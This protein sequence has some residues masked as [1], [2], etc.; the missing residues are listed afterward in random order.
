MSR[1]ESVSAAYPWLLLH[2]DVILAHCSCQERPSS[3]HS[4]GMDDG[5]AES[6][7]YG[8]FVSCNTGIEILPSQLNV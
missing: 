3:L 5:A 2:P 6:A 4:T 7:K 1:G 8:Q